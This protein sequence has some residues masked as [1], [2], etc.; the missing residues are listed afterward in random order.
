VGTEEHPDRDRAP[1][2]PERPEP[3]VV[4]G[5]LTGLL[6]EL[7]RVPEIELGDAAVV[8]P[9]AGAV[10]GRFELRRELGRGGFGVVYEAWDGEL[11]RAVAFKL[12]RPGRLKAGE[13]Q[14]RR[15]AEVIA[16]LSHPNLVTLFDVGRC[17]YGPY[18]VLELLRGGTLDERMRQGPIPLKDAVRFATEIAKGL[19]H[20]H[21]YGVVHRDLK[22]TN[23][24][25]CEAGGVKLLDFGMARAFGRRRVEG[26]TPV[27]M[28]PEQ[29]RGAPEDER[30][31]VFAL[32]V[33]LF[34]MLANDLPF[35]GGA[36]RSEVFAGAPP[37]LDVPGEPALGELVARM[38]EREPTKRPR[39]AAEVVAA[40][41]PILERLERAGASDPGPIRRV[42][43]GLRRALALVAAAALVALVVLLWPRPPAPSPPSSRAIA[44]LPFVN[45]SGSADNEYFS[46]GLTEEILHRLTRVRELKV[47]GRA[48]SFSLKNKKVDVTDVARR[49]RVD[50][51]LEGSVRRDKDRLRIA[52]ELVDASSGFRIWSQ[53]YDRRFE[54][55]FTIQDDIARQVVGA[56]ELVLSRASIGELNK[57]RAASIAAYDLYLRGRAALRL[58]TTQKNLE[59]AT[60]LF[61]QAIATDGQ[62]AQAY[63]GLCDAWLSRYELRRATESF[64]SAKTAC[65]AALERDRAAGEVYLA[66]G[67]LHL[68]SGNYPQAE[69]EFRRATTLASTQVDAILGLARAHQAQGRFDEAE[70]AFAEAKRIDPGYWGA[71]QELG[72]FLHSRGRYA[73]AAREYG[74][75]IARTPENASAYNNLGA[76]YFMAGDLE[77]SAEAWRQSLELAPTVGA[78][79]NTG[80]SYFYLGRFEEAAA[81]Y[82]KAVELAPRDHRLWGNLGD[83]YAHAAGRAPDAAAAYRKAVAVGEQ[84]LRINE[85][86]A[87]TIADLAA[88]HASLGRAERAR[89]LSA[90]ALALD[91]QNMGVRFNAALVAVRLGALDAALDEL[92]RAVK[93]G[94]PRQLL[95]VDAGLAP[96]RKHVR[97][98]ALAA[99]DAR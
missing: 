42:R 34:Q 76:A 57:P 7:A 37:A 3:A 91:P 25:L 14:L 21:A 93:L 38:L 15:E 24:F 40:L 43:R 1:E 84:R 80:S 17:E 63:A 85:A 55:V 13:D 61:E 56:L 88:Y 87:E 95:L 81:M 11:R 41:S 36:G 58:P 75:V 33:I 45:M 90:E 23:V 46:D 47:A 79:S 16:Q 65:E 29:H 62:F 32:G 18:L 8:W 74:E 48:A 5:A 28:A 12:V 54:D 26:G 60:A 64:D 82:Q 73:E 96:L 51:L 44:V 4:A 89:E 68:L 50:V 49:L 98:Q 2:R 99:S 72:L 97:F 9:Q 53:T 35:R 86:D 92:E 83:A 6:E 39:D 78:Y 20:A 71:Y 59:E 66:L 27:Y 30:S 67:K 19:A 77:R 52:A 70:K 31:D 10:I 22:P 69:S 94:Y